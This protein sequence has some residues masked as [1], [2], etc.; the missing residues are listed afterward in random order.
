MNNDLCKSPTRASAAARTTAVTA[1]WISKGELP[2]RCWF[3]AAALC[4]HGAAAELL[5][6]SGQGHVTTSSAD[7]H[8]LCLL[9]TSCSFRKAGYAVVDQI[10]AYYENLEKQPVWAQVKP[11]FL[12]DALPSAWNLR[13]GTRPQVETRRGELTPP[14]TLQKKPLHAEKHGRP[15]AMTGRSSSSPASRTGA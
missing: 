14:H 4:F 1:P 15:S 11:G 13:Y 9:S 10:C 3:Q 8:C 12:I 7:R 2:Q 5:D 6:S